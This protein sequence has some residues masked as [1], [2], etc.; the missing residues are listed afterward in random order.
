MGNEVSGVIGP[1]FHFF[2]VC[3]ADE[4]GVCL[5]ANRAASLACF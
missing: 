1:F 5:S 4:L 3:F 2:S